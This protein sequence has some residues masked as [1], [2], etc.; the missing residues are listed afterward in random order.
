MRSTPPRDIETTPCPGLISPWDHATRCGRLGVVRADTVRPRRWRRRKKFANRM[1]LRPGDHV[2]SPGVPRP[3][4]C[5]SVSDPAVRAR[6]IV[7]DF[8]V[9]C[10]DLHD[11]KDQI[12]RPRSWIGG[13]MVGGKATP[14]RGHEWLPVHL[15]RP[16]GNYHSDA[17]HTIERSLRGSRDADVRSHDRRSESLH[18]A[19][20]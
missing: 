3:P 7:H 10:A 19:G 4:T 17:V 13:R 5:R 15:V 6:Q 18:T 20:R 12:E 16:R 14:C 8:A 9:A 1:K 2:L 11:K